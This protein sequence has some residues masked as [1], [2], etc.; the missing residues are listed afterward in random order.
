VWPF[1]PRWQDPLGADAEGSVFKSRA[2]IR[3]REVGSGDTALVFIHG[4]GASLRYWG[5]AYDSLAARRR[6][7]F[8]D[9]AGFGGSDKA[10]APYDLEFH[11]EMIAETLDDLGIETLSLIGHSAGA[12]VAMRLA[13]VLG[14][15]TNVVAFGAPIF[16]S[17]DVAR[18]HLA[19]L[20]M[21]ERSMAE[22]SKLAVRMCRF[23]CDHRQ[24]SR[25]LAP[26]LVPRL[27]AAV[28]SDGVD[29]TWASFS[30]TFN[31]L[32]RDFDAR[33][34]AGGLG[35]RLTLV[36]GSEDETTPARLAAETLEPLPIDIN[37]VG[38][39]HH[40]P[41]YEPTACMRFIDA[42]A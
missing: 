32:L 29:H 2:G 35:S 10:A 24:L 17:E 1:S 9:L 11:S 14:R 26:L 41:L 6:L 3:I 36:Y 13:A 19:R 16:P 34:W 8:V 15:E 25:R 33:N 42:M 20:G 31:S 37:V 21:F 5:T 23:M 39:N 38:G 18:D 22:G 28:A 12:A 40:L 27:P 7:I 30:G 4:L